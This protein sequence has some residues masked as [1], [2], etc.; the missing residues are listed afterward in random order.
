MEPPEEE[1]T[2]EDSVG[3]KRVLDVCILAG[4]AVVV[5]LAAVRYDI[6][7]RIVE[8]SHQHEDWE[9]DEI[10]TLF[11]YLAVALGIFSLRRWIEVQRS[12]MLLRRHNEKLSKALSEIKH[13]R[14]ILPICAVCKKIRDDQGFW[15][16]VEDY[17]HAHTDAQF[18][19][20]V[21][22]D[23]MKKMYPGLA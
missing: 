23:C 20:G 9:M 14:G 7:E 13:L 2:Q 16:Q 4:I 1:T 15:R 11:L 6:L 10:L 19:H 5:Y 22:P 12:E 3:S 17:V 18:S 21:C 8:F